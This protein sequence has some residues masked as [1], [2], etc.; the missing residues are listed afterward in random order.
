[1]SYR[2]PIIFLVVKKVYLVLGVF[3]L[4]V[5]NFR[6]HA[7]MNMTSI[8]NDNVKIAYNAIGK[9]DTTLLFVHGAFIDMSYWTSQ[10]DFFKQHYQVII[11]DLA[12]HGKSGKNRSSWSIQEFGNDVC[13]LITTLHLKNVILIGH[14][15]GGDVILEVAVRCKG[16][17]IGFVGI[18]TFKNAGTPMPAVI[19]SQIDQVMVMLKT[20]F[21]ATSE[22]YV[23][24]ALTS[25]LT[26]K[27]IVD[28]VV[29]DYRNMDKNIGID[30]ISSSFAFYD[31]ERELMNQM[32]FKMY[33]IN[34]DNVPTN[35]AY[36]KKY[37]LS[38]Y[39]VV[40]I[41]GTCHFPMIE[42]PDEFNRLLQQTIGKI[43]AD[44]AHTVK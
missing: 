19:Q 3:L 5:S 15:M 42:D 39:E 14:S 33:L 8:E 44:S 20:D 11:V 10:I 43:K 23:R 17:V 26:D 35:D 27:S 40:T 1:V 7:Q 30:V 13:A 32:K 31:R 18:D 41:S 24:Q 9:G 29:S 2:L 25:P 4:L 36:L 34:V 12:G 28:R 6:I 21:A 37:A 16:V 38:G 22:N